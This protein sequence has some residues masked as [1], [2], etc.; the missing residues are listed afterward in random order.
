MPYPILFSGLIRTDDLSI[1]VLVSPQKLALQPQEFMG[2]VITEVGLPDDLA[3]EGLE[4]IREA[5][6]T[7]NIINSEYQ[8]DGPFGLQYYEARYIPIGKDE[9]LDIIRNITERV[10]TQEALRFNSIFSR[11]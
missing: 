11:S 4:K 8:M 10:K 5:L 2:K 1:T 3:Q 6:D 7:G 9:V